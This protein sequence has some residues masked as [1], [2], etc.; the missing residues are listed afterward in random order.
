MLESNGLSDLDPVS[1]LIL[2]FCAPLSLTNFI[3]NELFLTTSFSALFPL[4]GV[5]LPSLPLDPLPEVFPPGLVVFSPGE[6][7]VPPVTESPVSGV[8]LVFPF[9]VLS[10][11]PSVSI[12]LVWD[13]SPSALP[14]GLVLGCCVLS[15]AFPLLV[16]FSFG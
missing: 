3:E 16:E 14:S 4:S 8:V 2:F 10:L 1:T 13:D 11:P 12:I 15:D 6:V 9:S 5:I 7:W